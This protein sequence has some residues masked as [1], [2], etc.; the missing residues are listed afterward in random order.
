MVK[1]AALA[2][3][4]SPAAAPRMVVPVTP[5]QALPALALPAPGALNPVLPAPAAPAV[6]AAATPAQAVIARAP[7]AEAVALVLQDARSRETALARLSEMG[8]LTE[9]ERPAAQADASAFW[10]ELWDRS[11]KAPRYALDRSLPVPALVVERAEATYFVHPIA[12]GSLLPHGR[13]ALKRLVRAVERRGAGLYFEQNVPAFYGLAAGREVLDHAAADGGPARVVD[14]A[15][16]DTRR[17]AL[18]RALE[19]FL[20]W[21]SLAAPAAWL[22]HAPLSPAAWA[23]LLALGAFVWAAATSL[24]PLRRFAHLRNAYEARRLGLEGLAQRLEREA[25]VYFA[26]K[27]DPAA[28]GRLEPPLGLA[29]AAD[30]VVRR[31]KALADAVADDAAARGAKEVHLV[32]GYRHA[33]HAADR[34]SAMGPR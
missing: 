28:L 22:I 5:P 7:S 19:R 9:R 20:V 17:A 27:L 8:A 31:S 6:A 25:A 14:A 26:S 12:H 11:A 3:S 13:G 4:L 21:G 33:Y 30:P 32:V 24:R 10:S 2:L 23:L 29:D 34:L 15:R 1:A 16:A 18:R